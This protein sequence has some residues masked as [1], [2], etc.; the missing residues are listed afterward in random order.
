M[1]ERDGASLPESDSANN[2]LDRERCQGE[3]LAERKER[4]RETRRAE[5]KQKQKKKQRRGGGGFLVSSNSPS[6]FLSILPSVSPPLLLTVPLSSFLFIAYTPS[7][8]PQQCLPSTS[9]L[10]SSP[11]LSSA[12]LL[13][14]PLLP[15]SICLSCCSA[16]AA[17]QYKSHLS[18]WLQWA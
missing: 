15:P 12:P 1:V 16:H 18:A 17:R 10:S 4:R 6:T 5:K 7:P 2:S 11:F 3:D 13:S 14:S 9:S 8:L